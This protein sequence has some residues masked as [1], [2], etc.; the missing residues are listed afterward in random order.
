MTTDLAPDLIATWRTNYGLDRRTPEEAMRWWSDNNI[1]QAPAGAVAALGLCLDA[2]AR[3][4]HERDE[5]R[6]ADRA[7]CEE[8]ARLRAQMA[9]MQRV[10]RDVGDFD[11]PP[12]SAPC[13]CFFSTA[14]DRGPD[15]LGE[16]DYHKALRARLAEC[17]RLLALS[18]TAKILRTVSRPPLQ[19][20]CSLCGEPVHDGDCAAMGGGT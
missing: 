19:F 17:E 9:E 13:M 18:Q 14:E 4:T 11:Y 20:I 6:D 2:I 5:W 7:E 12:G 15:P 1:G 10:G 8:N 16:C 3:L